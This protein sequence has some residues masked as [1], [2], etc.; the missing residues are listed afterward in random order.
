MSGS[1]GSTT[2]QP[3]GTCTNRRTRSNR[4]RNSLL[5]HGGPILT[6]NRQQP[7]VEA[8]GIVNKRIVATGSL[9]DVR[10]RIGSNVDEVDLKGRTA[11]PGFYDAHAHIMGV[12]FA[13]AE[14]D[15]TPDAVSSIEEIASLVKERAASQPAGSWVLGRGYDQAMLAEGRIPTRHDI[16]AVSPDHPVILR[17]MC[18]HIVTANSKALE[19]AGITRNSPDPDDGTIDRDE[20][21]EP[22]GVLRESAMDPLF[23]AMG[24]ATEDE[25]V[26][27]LKLGGNLFRQHGVTSAGEAGIGRKEE[28]RAYQRANASGDLALRT[29]L[30]MRI[31]DTLDELIELGIMTGFG[32]EWMRI[33]NAKL[34]ADG[35]IGG[36]TARM[37]KPYEGE[38]DNFG[39]YMY[40][41]ENII[42]KIVRAH[43]A[44]F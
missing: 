1:R 24:E 19:L 30:M 36:R 34:F 27:A 11:V 29:W 38:T 44:G 4:V 40:P 7:E 14:I 2:S 21:G 10:S 28:L 6:M 31:D 8:V 20:H 15:L 23:D 17:R 9:S 13:A 37:S 39:I 33:G 35:S 22:T 43:K 25:I 41:P 42:E 3:C 26:D 16:D 5:I 32:D 18:H 12:G